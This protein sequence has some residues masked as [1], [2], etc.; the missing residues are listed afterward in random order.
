ML[1]GS[2]RVDGNSRHLEE[3]EVVALPL[4]PA[5]L[6]AV[7][8]LLHQN[9]LLGQVPLPSALLRQSDQL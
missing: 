8:F 1:I 3:E 6:A 2:Y 9:P 7:A 5:E 4:V